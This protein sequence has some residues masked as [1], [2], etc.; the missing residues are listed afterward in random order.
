MLPNQ[1]QKLNAALSFPVLYAIKF[2]NIPTPPDT[3][4]IYFA[5]K[6]EIYVLPIPA[7]NTIAIENATMK[8][9]AEICFIF[10]KT[11]NTKKF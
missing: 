7:K 11:K 6:G 1:N 3:I 10:I 8:Q 4:K 9:I 5:F 2:K